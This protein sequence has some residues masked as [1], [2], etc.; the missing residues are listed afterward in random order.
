MSLSH[1]LK[2]ILHG[3]DMFLNLKIRFCFKDPLENP[4]HTT[5]E[6]QL[7]P[8]WP[9]P[10]PNS[11]SRPDQVRIFPFT[12]EACMHAKFL[13]SCS[14]LCDPMNCS[15]PG[16]SVHGIRQARILEWVAMP[17][18]RGSS[19]PR[20]QTCIS[21]VSCMASRFFTTSAT[22]KPKWKQ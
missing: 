8:P 5:W 6:H 15:S 19:R 18:S 13:Q 17:S 10:Q 11:F 22:W 2:V 20:D 4:L 16:S 21:Y 12:V 3:G 1:E 14:T 9:C 7:P